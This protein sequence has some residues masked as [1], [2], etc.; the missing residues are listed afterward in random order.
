MTKHLAPGSPPLNVGDK[1]PVASEPVS[2]SGWEDLPD[3][4]EQDTQ[5]NLRKI[6]KARKGQTNA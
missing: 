6:A 5:D 2:D 1:A 3:T 4:S